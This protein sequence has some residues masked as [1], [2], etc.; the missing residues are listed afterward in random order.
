MVIKLWLVATPKDQPFI[1]ER[2]LQFGLMLGG[3]RLFS[4]F[5][6]RGQQ[7]LFL[8]GADRL[9]AEFHG[10]FFAVDH[11]G[12]LLEVRLPDFLG[13]ALREAHIV[14]V[15]LAFAGDVTFLHD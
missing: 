1:L 13:M 4:G 6:D 12:L 7:A 14:A 11:E 10:D 2:Q 5:F 9:R 15:L 3:H 8:E